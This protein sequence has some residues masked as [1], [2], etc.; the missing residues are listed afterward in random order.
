MNIHDFLA[1][2][3]EKAIVFNIFTAYLCRPT[4]EII[5]DRSLFKKLESSLEIVSPE[6]I[7]KCK[8]M[9]NSISKYTQLELL[10][11][12]TRLFMGPFK[13]L[14]Q[15][16][17]CMY[18]GGKSLM[19]DETLWVIN[20]Y[21]KMGLVYDNT[22]KDSPDHVAVETEFIYYLIF[23]GLKAFEAGNYENAKHFWEGQTEFFT[24]HYREW[25]PLF[26]KNISENS[27][28]DFYL[29]LADCLSTFTKTLIQHEFPVNLVES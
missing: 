17:S 6:S 24:K 5:S 8:E 11:E 13:I 7:E 21:E 26:C 12:Y 9:S 1:F 16:Y 28:N 18:F 27:K 23:S 20:Y 22:I 19:S 3:K 25:V 10:V 4:E 29:A 15:P 2:E 14:A